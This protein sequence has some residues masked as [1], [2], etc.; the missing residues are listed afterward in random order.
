MNVKI[1]ISRKDR[2]S[3][4]RLDFASKFLKKYWKIRRVFEENQHDVYKGKNP[5]I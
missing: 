4:L 1:D 2:I 3:Q 5:E